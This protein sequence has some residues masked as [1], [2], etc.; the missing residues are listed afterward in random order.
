VKIIIKVDGYEPKQES[1]NKT[2][3]THLN[4]FEY[5]VDG[6]NEKFLEIISKIIALFPTTILSKEVSINESKV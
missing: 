5:V 1:D 2:Y 3:D 4:A 6:S